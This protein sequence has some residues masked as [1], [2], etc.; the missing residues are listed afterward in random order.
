MESL[1]F[2]SCC[3]IGQCVFVAADFRREIGLSGF[4][5]PASAE[6]SPYIIFVQTNSPS[7]LKSVTA[8]T[9][10]E[11]ADKTFGW[12]VEVRKVPFKEVKDGL[13]DEVAA[14]GT[15]AVSIVTSPFSIVVPSP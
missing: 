10:L 2:P 15:A 12:K 11:L 5:H 8:K 7:I 9:I 1:N 13:F 6:F 4:R 3:Q 14:A